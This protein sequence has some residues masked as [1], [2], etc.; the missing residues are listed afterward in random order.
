MNQV[1]TLLLKLHK[2]ALAGELTDVFVVARSE[3]G[4]YADAYFCDDLKEMLLE[5][6]NAKIRARTECFKR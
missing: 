3:D 6:G 4:Q 5:V 1:A 2:A